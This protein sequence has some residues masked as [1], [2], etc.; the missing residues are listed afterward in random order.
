MKLLLVIP[1]LTQLNTPYPSTACLS[2]YLRSKGFDVSQTDLGITLVDEI[3]KPSFLEKVFDKTEGLKLPKPL[4]RI[5]NHRFD[6]VRTITPV[7]RF[8]RGQ[9]PSLAI[10]IA[11]RTLLP[12]G[13]RFDSLG[14][15]EWAFGVSGTTDMAQHLCTLY[16]E[17]LSDYIRETIDPF[18]D[19]IRYAESISSFARFK[20]RLNKKNRMWWAFPFHFQAASMLLCVALSG[21]GSIDRR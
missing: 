11:N 7:M 17:D 2:G 9:D 12:E 20:R 4:R 5:Y 6:Y 14:D 10:R 19:L 16:L 15:M 18:F 3:F 21:C 13:P 1:P 8:L